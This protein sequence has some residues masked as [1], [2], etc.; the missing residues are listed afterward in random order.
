MSIAEQKNEMIILADGT[1]LDNAHV[2][3]TSA[4][5]IFLYIQTK[6]I[7]FNGVFGLLSDAAKVREIRFVYING[8]EETFC[9]FVDL[10]SLRKE[11][12]GQMTA[13]LQKVAG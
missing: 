3:K 5:E 2:L 12:S 8:T 6:G 11:E 9:G 10:V 13:I 1:V 7:T 4:W